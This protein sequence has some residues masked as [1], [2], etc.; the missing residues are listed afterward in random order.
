MRGFFSGIPSFT[1]VFRRTPTAPA[2][3]AESIKI[4]DVRIATKEFNVNGRYGFITIHK[5]QEVNI[6]S[7]IYTEE[8]KISYFE[9]EFGQGLVAPVSVDDLLTKTKKTEPNL[10]LETTQLAAAA[11]SPTNSGEPIKVGD[12]RFATEEFQLD[13]GNST[14]L[15]DQQ[16][17]IVSFYTREN[18]DMIYTI[19]FRNN[20]NKA[21]TEQVSGRHLLPKMKKKDPI[22]IQIGTRLIATTQYGK[23]YRPRSFGV[24]N[25]LTVFNIYDNNEQREIDNQVVNIDESELKYNVILV[26]DQTYNSFNTAKKK[27]IN[28]TV[29]LN[30]SELFEYAILDDS[31]PSQPRQIT[32]GGNR[33]SK[34]FLKK[35]KKS[36]RNYM[37]AM[38][39][40]I[41]RKRRKR[42]VS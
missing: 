8:G 1:Q 6:S 10:A 14:I 22:P 29:V 11:A 32:L 20:D 37:R 13:I 27:V 35:Q 36:K 7:I 31:Q 18:G 40:F 25:K 19:E 41:T 33:K 12:V 9:V 28:K 15:K 42:V 16:V 21:T 39:N 38:R 4:G 34:S 17:K 3:S 24:G 2:N 23:L 5:D 26:V 30:G